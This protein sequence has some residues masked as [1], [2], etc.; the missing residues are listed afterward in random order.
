MDDLKFI[1]KL[2]R[3]KEYATSNKFCI[4]NQGHYS[5][6]HAKIQGVSF[7]SKQNYFL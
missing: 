2:Y 6:I 5:F 3:A 7:I 1:D 4:E